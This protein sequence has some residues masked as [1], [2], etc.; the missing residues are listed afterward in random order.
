MLNYTNLDKSLL[1]RVVLATILVKPIP[2]IGHWISS[3][4]VKSFGTSS[5]SIKQGPEESNIWGNGISEYTRA[6]GCT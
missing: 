6:E 4:K 5:A 3:V 1:L 2:Y